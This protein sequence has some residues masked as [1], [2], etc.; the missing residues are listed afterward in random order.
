M[1]SSLSFLHRAI[2]L[3]DEMAQQ[4]V[5]AETK[6]DADTL[7]KIEKEVAT[8]YLP[9]LILDLCIHARAVQAL[10]Q[11]TAAQVP[12]VSE[13][14]PVL[15]AVATVITCSCPISEFIEGRLEDP[16]QLGR[17]T[18]HYLMLRDE[19]RSTISMLYVEQPMV[20]KLLVAAKP[21]SE[22]TAVSEDVEK[23]LLWLVALSKKNL[24]TWVRPSDDYQA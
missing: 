4:K 19:Q 13:V 5:S 6:S 20:G 17:R 10:Q 1:T 3:L 24:I 15:T 9:T 2:G 8:G 21:L 7:A 16:F 14:T 11:R 22:L 23:C 18:T 12:V